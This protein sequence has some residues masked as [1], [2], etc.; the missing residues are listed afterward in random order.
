M[1]IA[2][3]GMMRVGEVLRL[4]CK[5]IVYRRD[6][7]LLRIQN[8]KTGVEQHVLLYG[9]EIRRIVRAAQLFAEKSGGDNPFVLGMTYGVARRK[10]RSAVAALGFEPH[11]FTFHSLR[12]GG[13]TDLAMQDVS[14]DIIA[15]RGRWRLIMNAT[16]YVQLGQSLLADVRIS[17]QWRQR[18]KV[19]KQHWGARFSQ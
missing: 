17:P 5:G 3:L 8:A 10:F 6:K 14:L 4:C 18:I 11:R 12:H 7:V 13:A 15:I 19:L 1:L 2:Q 16:R 9:L